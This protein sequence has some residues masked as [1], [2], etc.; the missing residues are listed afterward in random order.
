MKFLEVVELLK[1]AGAASEVLVLDLAK[2]N[3][4]ILWHTGACVT[5]IKTLAPSEDKWMWQSQDDRYG[6]TKDLGDAIRLAN[7][8]PD[9]KRGSAH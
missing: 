7:K 6:R 4:L 8:G 1:A 3:T 2:D 9:G 5:S